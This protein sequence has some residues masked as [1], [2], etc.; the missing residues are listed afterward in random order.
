MSHDM[1]SSEGDEFPEAQSASAG[2]GPAH[3]PECPAATEGESIGVI[4]LRRLEV[5]PFSDKQIALAGDL[6]RPGR[7]R[8]RQCSTVRRGAGQDARPHGGPHL[9]DRQRQYPG[10][11]AS[12]PTDVSAGLQA[13]VESACQLC[14]AYDALR[15]AE[16]AATIW[17]FSAHHGPLPSGL[18]SVL[19]NRELGQRAARW[20]TRCR[21]T[22]RPVV[23]PKA[24][25]F[26]GGAAAVARTGPPHAS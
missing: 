22:F 17:H 11:I 3:R 6:R 16:G 5:N 20:S 19:I 1:L 26:P 9:P 24:A 10:V 12:S 7:D 15:T 14:G 23:R 21:F 8:H 2:A 13:I 25:E 4:T 18:D